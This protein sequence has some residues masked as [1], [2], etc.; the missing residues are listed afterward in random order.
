[1]FIYIIV[2]NKMKIS[3]SDR[4]SPALA[5]TVSSL[6]QHQINVTVHEAHQKTMK[7][8]KGWISEGE[9]DS[10]K[11]RGFFPSNFLCI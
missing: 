9:M 4:M 6:A 1:M 3:M 11:V 2:F 10:L 8:N 7:Q 5:P